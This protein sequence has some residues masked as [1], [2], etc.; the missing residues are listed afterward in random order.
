MTIRHILR[1]GVQVESVSGRRISRSIWK[2]LC[3]ECKDRRKD[4]ISGYTD[5]LR[6]PGGVA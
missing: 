1:N 5:N 4:K 6:Q 2:E 3:V